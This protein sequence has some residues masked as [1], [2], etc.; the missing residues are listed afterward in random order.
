VTI[1]L[2]YSCSLCGLCRVAVETAERVDGQHIGDWMRDVVTPTLV[3]DH[4]RRSPGCKPL[5]FTE[6][7]IP[8]PDDGEP[9]GKPRLS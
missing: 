8:M 9:L 6:V 2:K 1:E 4:E 7:M 5:A 3:A